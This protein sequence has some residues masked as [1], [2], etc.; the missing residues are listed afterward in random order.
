MSADPYKY[1]RIEARELVEHLS[2]GLLELEKGASPQLVARLLRYA[3]TRKGAARVVK[4]LRIAA[5]AHELEEQ[6]SPLRE[7]SGATPRVDTML[8]E[9]DKIAPLLAALDQPQPPQSQPEIRSQLQQQPQPVR[10]NLVPVTDA[11][12]TVRADV[13]EIEV[14]VDTV[15]AALSELSALRSQIDKLED[16]RQLAELCARQLAAPRRSESRAN[17]TALDKVRALAEEI[18]QTTR[19]LDAGMT[20][21]LERARR[22]LEHARGQA[23]QLRLTPASAIFA[24]LERAVRDAAHELGKDVRVETHGA[25]TRLDGSVLEVV[26]SA[27]FHVVRN[28][29]AHGIERP[30][31]RLARGKP[32]YGTI[33]I[34]V[35]RSGS[36]VTFLC[37][38]DGAGLDAA[39]VRGALARAGHTM[40][41]SA[42][43]SSTELLDRLLRTRVSTAR[44]V[45][46][47]SGRGVGLDVLR[48]AAERL[49]GSVRL[50]SQPG[51]GFAAELIVPLT[52]AAVEALVVESGDARVSLPLDAVRRS[53]RIPTR[54]IARGASGDQLVHEGVALPFLPL[55]V[56]LDQKDARAREFTTAVILEA[57]GGAFGLGVQ[58]VAGTKTAVLRPLPSP[59]PR[60]PFVLGA[61]LDPR[62]NPELVLDPEGLFAHA[63]RGA[64]SSVAPRAIPPILI[65]DDSL[66][67]RMLEQSILESSGYTVDLACSAE[68]GLQRAH[69]RQYGLFL[70]DVEMPGMDGF[71]F[72]ESTQRDPEL[73]RVP[74]VLVSSRDAP[75]DLARGK[76]AGARGYIVKGRFDQRE[77]LDLIGKLLASA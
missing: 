44:E 8:A 24:S 67:T 58:R 46:A 42:N 39:A 18:S 7:A 6:L 53:V 25:D 54:E 66:T 41:A 19:S 40:P 50:D 3:H 49:G 55:A 23:E 72:V 17:A 13:G 71:S 15:N 59:M 45:T 76:A 74:A 27:F 11:D 20:R 10:P 48:E 60:N 43:A 35:A 64:T 33:R 68:E 61:A 36:R 1:F 47:V 75:E 31:E 9:L 51:R 26:Q 4:H 62:G 37:E 22:E 12:R 30:S 16:L 29:V 28:A 57:A 52:A 32:R 70:V 2:K 5:A 69:E 73:R 38:D 56:A 34:R 77:L 14:V 65:V 21:T 63:T